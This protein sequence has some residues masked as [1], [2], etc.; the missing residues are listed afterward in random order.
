MS[1]AYKTYEGG[2]FFVTLT[3]VGWIDVFIRREYCDCLIQNL[4]YCQEKKGLQLYAYCIMSSHVHLIAAAKIGTLSDILRDFKSY[5]AK[6]LLQLIQDNPQESRKEWLLY[7]FQHFARKNNHNIEFQFWQHH[8]HP[9]DLSSNELI[10]QK[11]S[12]IHQNP[13]NAGLVNEAQDY[14]YSSANLLSPLKM[15]PL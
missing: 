5:T 13:V 9:I 10:E 14:F 8:N 7:L 3:V 11:L 1:R 6:Q 15:L 4:K 2:L 12:Y